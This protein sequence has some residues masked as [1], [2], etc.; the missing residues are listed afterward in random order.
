MIIYIWKRIIGVLPDVVDTQ[1]GFKGFRAE[2]VRAIVPEMLEKKF[3]FD[4]ELLIKARLNRADSITRVPIAWID[5]EVLS[6]TT[7]IQPYLP[8]LQSMVGMYR[9]YLSPSESADEFAAF[10]EDLDEKAW[11]RLVDNIPEAITKREPAAFGGFSEV[12]AEQLRS[13]MDTAAEYG[14]TELMSYLKDN[15][16]IGWDAGTCGAAAYGDQWSTVQWLR[17]QGVPWDQYVVN[18]AARNGRIDALEWLWEQSALGLFQPISY[19]YAV[20]GKQ[21]ESRH[22]VIRWLLE[23]IVPCDDYTRV[24]MFIK[25]EDSETVQFLRETMVFRKQNE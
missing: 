21:I 15:G 23:H 13:Y 18:Y 2:T 10:I 16:D 6:T 7:D 17:K 19:L 4:I 9:T 1:C 5:S 25:A 22:A 24:K 8:M 12:T 20:A 11:N 3:A 14:R